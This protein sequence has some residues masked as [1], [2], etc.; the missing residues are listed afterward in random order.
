MIGSEPVVAN[1]AKSGCKQDNP[2]NRKMGSV[3]SG[4]LWPTR[5]TVAVEELRSAVRTRQDIKKGKP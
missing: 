5:L 1:G 3:G 2:Q 4:M